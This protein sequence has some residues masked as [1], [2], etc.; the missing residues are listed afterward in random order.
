MRSLFVLMNKSQR[1]IVYFLKVLYVLGL[2]KNSYSSKITLKIKV[3]LI[4]D[5]I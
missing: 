2:T 3:I 4:G 1:N 5:K